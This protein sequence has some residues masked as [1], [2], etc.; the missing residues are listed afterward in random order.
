MSGGIGAVS[1]GISEWV[2]VAVGFVVLVLLVLG[3]W[4]LAKLLMLALKG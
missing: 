3:G 2:V 1:A 4:K